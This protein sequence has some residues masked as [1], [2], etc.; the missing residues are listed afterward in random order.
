MS[1][2]CFVCGGDGAIEGKPGEAAHTWLVGKIYTDYGTGVEYVRYCDE[3]GYEDPG[4][5]EIR[6]C[7]IACPNCSGTGHPKSVNAPSE[8][9]E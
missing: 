1:D 8:E 2:T 9:G 4:E 5:G 7:W 6:G 3:C